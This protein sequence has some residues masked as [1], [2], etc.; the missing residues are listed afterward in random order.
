MLLAV[1]LAVVAMVALDL[2]SAE[3]RTRAW[4]PVIATVIAAALPVGA[5]LPHVTFEHV[6]AVPS[7]DVTHP[8]VAPVASAARWHSALP[9]LMIRVLLPIALIIGLARDRTAPRAAHLV[10]F[11][12]A[13][14]AT[15]L[16]FA[17]FRTLRGGAAPEDLRTC[18]ALTP[19]SGSDAARVR[20][21]PMLRDHR[22]QLIQWRD[23]PRLPRPPWVRGEIPVTIAGE[24]WTLRLRAASVIAEPDDLRRAD[25][26]LPALHFA[27]VPSMATGPGG[28]VLL[29]H[30]PGGKLYAVR[31]GAPVSLR[32]IG[33]L[34]RPPR[35]PLAML[36][37]ALI[38]CL[39]ALVVSRPA[40][41]LVTV[42]APYRAMHLREPPPSAV[43]AWCALILIEASLTTMHVLLPYL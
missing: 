41:V 25:R 39:A 1:F 11:A 27:S 3:S 38:G 30:R 8:C 13:L 5:I 15:V 17:L 23:V 7:F 40:R 28:T 34:L 21:L 37:L 9:F 33:P 18:G 32:E 10:G 4:L 22:L 24:P 26:P 14:T 29:D 2:R 43:P 36:A 12:F 31:V 6:A 35:W 42:F 19:D 16:S 20:S